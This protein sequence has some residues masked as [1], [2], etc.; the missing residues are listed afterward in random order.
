M[1][2]IRT[3]D[4]EIHEPGY[5]YPPF[6]EGWWYQ[7][8]TYGGH[9]DGS[10]DW[11]RRT[12]NGGWMND[13]G[14]PVLAAADGTVSSIDKATGTVYLVHF[15]GFYR[16]EYRHMRMVN[17][18]DGQK[19]E[20]GDKI[21][22]IGAEGITGRVPSPH[23]HHVHF[24]RDSLQETWGDRHRVKQR[25]Y[26]RAID[27]SV[28]DSNN[29]PASANLPGPVMIEGPAPKA[30]WESAFQESEALRKKTE[31][32]LARRTASLEDCRANVVTVTAEREAAKEEA[33]GTFL[34]LTTTRAELAAANKRIEELEANPPECGP[35]LEAAAA[36][37]AVKIEEA[38]LEGRQTMHD[39][40]VIATTG[41]V[42]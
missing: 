16:T 32:Q 33:A 8:A 13:L 22:E 39:E 12:K 25:F 20:R 14:D 21:G 15:G 23:L 35:L 7:G 3:P 2:D 31:D 9:S 11:N 4:D 18:K 41:L 36:E 6:R 5:Y 38:R 29:Q 37:A 26:G 19:V 24:K 27:A 10:V 1:S 40:H 30:T 34:T 17:V 28:M 42:P